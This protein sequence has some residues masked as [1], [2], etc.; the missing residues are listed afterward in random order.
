MTARQPRFSVVIPTYRRDDLLEQS[1]ASVLAQTFT[2]FRVVIADNAST[3]RTGEI[4]QK[5]APEARVVYVDND[6]L[7]LTHARALL[8]RMPLLRRF[9]Q[10]AEDQI[11]QRGLTSGVNS[12]LEQANIPLSPGEVR[13]VP[14]E[15]HSPFQLGIRGAELIFIS[16]FITPQTI[17]WCCF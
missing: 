17:C 13:F 15:V 4:A 7:V 1:L 2:D 3:D 14:V 9:S 11:A 8:D 5:V 12:A 10:S 16:P 6:P